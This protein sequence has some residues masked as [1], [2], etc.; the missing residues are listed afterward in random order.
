MHNHLRN[1]MIFF[2]SYRCLIMAKNQSGEKIFFPKTQRQLEQC[3]VQEIEA[4][5]RAAKKVIEQR[6]KTARSKALNA[7]VVSVLKHQFSLEEIVIGLRDKNAIFDKNYKNGQPQRLYQN[8]DNEMDIWCGTGRQ[9]EWLREKIALGHE[10]DEFMMFKELYAEQ[11]QLDIANKL[12]K[13]CS[14]KTP[15]TT[16]QELGEVP[17]ANAN[18]LFEMAKEDAVIVETKS[19]MERRSAQRK[20]QRTSKKAKQP[21]NA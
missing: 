13:R 12:I 3:S 14:G 8:P 11:D 6:Q 18:A 16:I 21:A 17:T 9:P 20:A 7:L 4:Y 1:E 5:A 15:E 10:L 2:N 19:A